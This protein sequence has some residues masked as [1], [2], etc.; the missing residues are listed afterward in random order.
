M[1]LASYRDAIMLHIRWGMRIDKVPVADAAAAM[2]ARFGWAEATVD[3]EAELV[4]SR[5]ALGS[6]L[7]ELLTGEI[8]PAIPGVPR[9]MQAKHILQETFA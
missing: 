1:R 8:P 7:L 9:S 3:G 6:S 5:D 2:V 4:V